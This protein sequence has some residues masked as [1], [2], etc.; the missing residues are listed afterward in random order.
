MEKQIVVIPAQPERAYSGLA[1]ELLKLSL[2][3]LISINHLITLELPLGD[4]YLL[5]DISCT[6]RLKGETLHVGERSPSVR[7][8]PLRRHEQ[9]R[10]RSP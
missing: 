9:F 3:E 2:R 4:I 6:L 7:E 5:P 1:E 8:R 10:R